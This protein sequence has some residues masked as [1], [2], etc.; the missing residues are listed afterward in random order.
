MSNKDFSFIPSSF[1]LTL[2][3]YLHKGSLM[4]CVIVFLVLGVVFFLTNQVGC[5][6]WK[7]FMFYPMY[8]DQN[9]IE[10][11]LKLNRVEKLS[12]KLYIESQSNSDA[13]EIS[14]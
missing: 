11:L 8:N 9:I 13:G 7:L 10:V 2:K 1:L 5:S 14:G 6:F 4:S 3:P 12:P